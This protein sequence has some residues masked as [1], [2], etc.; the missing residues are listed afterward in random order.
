MTIRHGQNCV[1]NLG[2]D[3]VRKSK[4]PQSSWAARAID[5]F[6]Q[7]K[8]KSFLGFVMAVGPATII[9]A[10]A[11]VEPITPAL[12]YWVVS[13]LDPFIK[14]QSAD[15]LAIQ[16]WKLRDERQALKDAKDDFAKTASPSAQKMIDYY[17]KLI[18]Q[19][20]DAIDRITARPH[21]TGT[22]QQVE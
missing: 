21:G 18:A 9:G 16:F 7:H 20:E 17:T 19:H 15:H 12:H 1:R 6:L 13:K 3:M 22:T 10:Y 8:L 2:R 11:Y 4:A 14:V 5:T